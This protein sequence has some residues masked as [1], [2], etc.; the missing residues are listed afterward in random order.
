MLDST[1]LMPLAEAS[2]AIEARLPSIC[3]SVIGPVLPAMSL[4][5]A[6][7]TTTFGRERDDV[8][9]H[10]DQHLRRGLRADAAADI[11]LAGEERA[12]AR[13]RPVIGDRVAHEDHIGARH[14]PIGVPIATDLRPV[15]QA[16]IV[17]G[18]GAQRG[19]QIRTLEERRRQRCL[20]RRGRRLSGGRGEAEVRDER[21]QG[22]RT[23]K[24]A[25]L[26]HKS[27]IRQ[28]TNSPQFLAGS[29]QA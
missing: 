1:T 17:V 27:P 3:S 24:H 15:A 18:D 2:S 7:I 10:P 22:E 29:A 23:R 20:R 9:P 11:V 16:R 21:D 28:L 26:R 6:R 4:V 19:R 13:L 12:E 8:R 25:P 5:P 14:R